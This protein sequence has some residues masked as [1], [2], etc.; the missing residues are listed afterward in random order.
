M[1]YKKE[2]TFLQGSPG[3]MGEPGP[4]GAVGPRVRYSVDR[5][6]FIL[7]YLKT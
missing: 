6:Q 5:N 2:Y 3:E 4:S 1:N 7:T